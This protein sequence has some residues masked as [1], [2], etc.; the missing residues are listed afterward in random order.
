MAS[1]TPTFK[2]TPRDRGGRAEEIL[3]PLTSHLIAF[4]LIELLVVAIISILAAL[5]LPA[6]KSARESAKTVQCLHNLKQ[7][8]TAAFIYAD[9]NDGR[10]TRRKDHSCQAIRALSWRLWKKSPTFC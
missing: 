6:L 9:D 3:L 4:I 5:L 8:G 10:T 2:H 7:I 1:R